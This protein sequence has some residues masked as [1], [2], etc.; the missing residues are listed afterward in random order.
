MDEENIAAADGEG[1]HAVD[2]HR[3]FANGAAEKFQS[4]E[5]RS[6]AEDRFANG[7]SDAGEDS[8]L[9]AAGLELA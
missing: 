7:E 8:A 1:R 5:R 4:E 2:V 6:D 3:E 9:G